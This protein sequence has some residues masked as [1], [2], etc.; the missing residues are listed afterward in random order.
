MTLSS[1]ELFPLLQCRYHISIFVLR[2]AIP[3]ILSQLNPN[4]TSAGKNVTCGDFPERDL[5]DSDCDDCDEDK[6]NEQEE[7]E[8]E[9]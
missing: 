9:L 6:E 2:H 5:M 1:F 3:P 4:V 8:D 7:E